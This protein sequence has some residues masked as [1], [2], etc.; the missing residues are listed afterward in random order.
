VI[1]TSWCREGEELLV[2]EH[3]HSSLKDLPIIIIEHECEAAGYYW[4]GIDISKSMVDVANDR[5]TE[6]GDLF[7][8]DIF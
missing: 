2:D 5:D 6:N 3:D 7:H 4:T 1:R 8:H